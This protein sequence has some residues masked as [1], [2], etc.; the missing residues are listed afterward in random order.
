M[1]L[2]TV[3]NIRVLLGVVTVMFGVLAIV[4]GFLTMNAAYSVEGPVSSLLPLSLAVVGLSFYFMITGY[5]KKREDCLH[6]VK[7]K[8]ALI[9]SISVK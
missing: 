5:I 1:K 8:S 3:K 9:K 7:D 4:F 2:K 6:R